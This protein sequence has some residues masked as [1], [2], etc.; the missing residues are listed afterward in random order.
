MKFSKIAIS[1]IPALAL[2]DSTNDTEV[3]IGAVIF[4]RH[5]DRL[6]K[7]TQILTPVGQLQEFEAGGY[8]RDRYMSP[9]SQFYIASL[10]ETYQPAQIYA[11][12]ANSD[13]LQKSQM[14]FLQGLFPPFDT[15]QG[16]NFNTV[17]GSSLSN[18]SFAEGP[19][20]G[21]QYVSQDGQDTDSPDYI[22]TSGSGVCP[23]YTTASNAYYQSS[24]FRALNSS[25]F[26]FYQSLYPLLEGSFNQ[27]QL[28]YSNAFTIF[29]FMNVNWVHNETFVNA[30]QSISN[31][32]DIFFQV[33]TLQDQ[34]SCALNWNQ[35]NPVVNVAGRTAA[36]I[37]ADY[38]ALMNS[39]YAD[40]LSNNPNSLKLAVFHGA[41]ATFYP[42]FGVLGLI[43][44]Q[45][46]NFT[47]LINY[48]TTTTFE[49]IEK[50]SQTYVRFSIRNGTDASTLLSSYPILGA[51]DT[52]IPFEDFYNAISSSSISELSDWCETCEAWSLGFCDIY[53][54]QYQDF[55]VSSKA[56]SLSLA[57]AGGIGAGATI[58]AFAMVGAAVFAYYRHRQSKKMTLAL[59]GKNVPSMRSA[60]SDA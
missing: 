51:T 17:T 29:D 9:N 27:S 10:N 41:Y 20:S 36:Y 30:T 50:S 45:P 32:S 21:Y 48:A 37:I 23:A 14:A 11:Q 8:I 58:G 54:P 43:E 44:S 60:N 26:E 25:T 39:S 18:G 28:S 53:T 40:N 31:F 24:E 34:Y 35:S 7:P 5:G 46:V 49:L 2:A 42:L 22:W 6:T 52:L 15:I 33:R 38:L 3:V 56:K 13:V 19:L 47:G 1:A 16:D 12:V 55:L 57:A 59:A 4:A